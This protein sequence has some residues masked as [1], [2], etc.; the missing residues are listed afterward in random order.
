MDLSY[1]QNIKNLI[2]KNNGR[3]VPILENELENYLM[4][5]PGFTSM[6]LNDIINKNSINDM[7]VIPSVFL[8]NKTVDLERHIDLYSE[9]DKRNFLTGNYQCSIKKWIKK[10]I[11][12]DKPIN[13]ITSMYG[14]EKLNGH[15]I[16]IHYVVKTNTIYVH[17]PCG[18][19]SNLTEDKLETLFF[20]FI[21]PVAVAV[22]KI[23]N[24]ENIPQIQIIDVKH[25]LTTESYCQDLGFFSM[26]KILDH[27]VIYNSFDEMFK[28]LENSVDVKLLSSMIL[29]LTS[30]N[31]YYSFLIVYLLSIKL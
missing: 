11:D 12:S 16:V 1:Y 23:W 2:Q 19:L 15:S 20:Y 13:F 31:N 4:T 7:R 17:D 22:R 18:H 6:L 27:L 30:N 25:V 26:K 8:N 29:A 5:Q 14:D 3:K 10:M 24:L 21:N 28:S 9:R